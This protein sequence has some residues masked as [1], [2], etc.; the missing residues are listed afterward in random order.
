MLQACLP[1]AES[2]ATHLAFVKCLLEA[3]RLDMEAP[4]LLMTPESQHLTPLYFTTLVSESSTLTLIV[5]IFNSPRFSPFSYGP[6][7]ISA[8]SFLLLPPL[9]PCLPPQQGHRLE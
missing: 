6:L 8:L 7:I 1:L 4:P 3:S 2:S 5:L 9:R